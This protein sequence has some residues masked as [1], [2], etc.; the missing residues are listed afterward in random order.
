MVANFWWSNRGQNKIHLVWVSV[1]FIYS[2][3]RIWIHPDKLISQVLKAKYFPNKDVF[4]A[5]LGSRPSFTWR[6]ILVAQYL[7][8]AGCRWSV[9]S[10][11]RIR[12]LFDPWL[13]RP[14]SF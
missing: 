9:G 12:V 10:R 6:S 5:T 7:F 4:L 3:W 2:I 1:S 14:R 11:S 13:P 8:R